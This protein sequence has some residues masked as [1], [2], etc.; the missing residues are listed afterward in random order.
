MP[1]IEKGSRYIMPNISK[2]QKG[3]DPDQ[4]LQMYQD[5]A[6]VGSAGTNEV[7][8]RMVPRYLNKSVRK[9]FY[10]QEFKLWGGFV[11]EFTSRFQNRKKIKNATK[12][13]RNITRKKNEDLNDFLDRCDDLRRRHQKEAALYEDVSI[14]QDRE[15]CEIFIKAQPNKVMRRFVRNTGPTTLKQAKVAVKDYLYADSSDEEDSDSESYLSSSSDYSGDNTDNSSSESSESEIRQSRKRR[16]YKKKKTH[17]KTHTK[18]K[19]NEE[20]V[21]QGGPDPIE[22]LTK[23]ISNLS[24][25]VNEKQVQSTKTV[26]KD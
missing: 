12:K 16:E 4:W 20:K 3:D 26:E 9:W 24:L 7:K 6:Q 21:T 15:L 8:L 5:A 13:L 1:E 14:I 19:K 11:E 23:Q 10:N 18:N 25:M 17:V 22:L 2:F